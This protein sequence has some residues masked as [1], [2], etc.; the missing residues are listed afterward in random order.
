[1]RWY[2]LTL[3][4]DLFVKLVCKDYTFPNLRRLSLKPN[5]DRLYFLRVYIS[6]SNEFWCRLPRLE[7]LTIIDNMTHYIRALPPNDCFQNLKDV[8]I[9]VPGDASHM[10]RHHYWRHVP[11]NMLR[12]RLFV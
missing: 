1:M 9:Q 4:Y 5:P 7:V 8:I 11:H 6:S 3:S 12:G 10:Q 2:I